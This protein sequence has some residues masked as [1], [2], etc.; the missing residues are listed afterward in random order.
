MIGIIAQNVGQLICPAPWQGIFLF[1]GG[2]HDLGVW[3]SLPP[4]GELAPSTVGADH[5]SVTK[6]F[7][8]VV[9]NR[10]ACSMASPDLPWRSARLRQHGAA[11]LVGIYA[12]APLP[13]GLRG[14]PGSLRVV[15]VNRGWCR[16]SA[17]GRL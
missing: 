10:M 8:L 3:A 14:R 12:S 7:G 5:L 6:G 4:E 2:S 9:G 11:G 1:M 13:A 16:A 17:C 15:P